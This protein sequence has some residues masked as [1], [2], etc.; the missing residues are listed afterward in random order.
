[1]GNKI[2]KEEFIKRIEEVHPFSKIEI[3]EYDGL[4][5]PAIFRCAECGENFSLKDA[6]GIF[7]RLNP[8]VNDKHFYS[9]EQKIRYFEAQQEDLQVLNIG[10]VKSQI[11]CKK[12][13][14][15]FERTT[16][17]LMAS[18]DSCP[19][20]NNGFQKQTNSLEKALQVLQEHYPTHHYEI[21]EYSTFHNECKI[22]CQDCQFLYIGKFDSFLQSRGC[23]R[24]YRKISKGEMKIQAW[25]EKNKIKFVQQKSLDAEK[26]TKRYKFDFFLPDRNLAIEYNGEQHYTEKRGRFDPLEVTQLRDKQKQDYCLRQG[27]ELFIIPYW[28]YND[29]EQILNLKL[30]DQS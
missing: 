20:C 7:S 10:R 11:R 9:R 1:M 13:G 17:S 27:I 8:C 5:K 24:C 18:F 6:S 25:L 2:T 14:E 29:I 23:P 16:V 4:R 3:I 21:I 30:N 26:E 22:K 19:N 28:D 15:N 12:C